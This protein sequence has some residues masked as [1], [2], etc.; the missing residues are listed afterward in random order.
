MIVRDKDACAYSVMVYV[1]TPGYAELPAE[2]S[3]DYFRGIL[4][5]YKQ[6]GLPI[7]PL[8]NALRNT[9]NEISELEAQAKK[10]FLQ[11]RFQSLRFPG[12]GNGHKP[13]RGG[14]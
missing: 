10:D 1:M 11:P 14:R 12:K 9:R 6:N 7:Q 2:P 13:P 3:R 4:D 5:G 8:Y